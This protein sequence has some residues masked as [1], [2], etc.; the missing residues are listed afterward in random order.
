M[1]DA[2]PITP[3]GIEATLEEPAKRGSF[4][5]YKIDRFNWIT[6][7]TG[8]YYPDILEEACVL[9]EPVL[10]LFGELLKTSESSIRLFEQ[11]ND[12]GNGWTRV[13]LARIFRKYVSPRTP[14]EM[15]KAKWKAKEIIKTF[16]DEFRPIQKVQAAFLTRPIPDEA[17][18]ALLW[19]YSY[20]E[21]D[22]R[23]ANT[24]LAI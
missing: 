19:E 14:V 11:I 22:P 18:C 2:L 8:E 7:A 12:V 24:R 15:L 10:V 9:Y 20:L 4:A 23:T 6:L 1:T 16:G 17:L 5:D 13:Q 3:E 21:N